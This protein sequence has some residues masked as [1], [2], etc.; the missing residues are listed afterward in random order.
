M[1]KKSFTLIRIKPC[2]RNERRISPART[3]KKTWA[4]ENI[5]PFLSLNLKA[6]LFN[7]FRLFSSIMANTLYLN[8]NRKNHRTSA[9]N[10]EEVLLQKIDAFIF[11]SLEV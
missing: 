9:G 11:D 7:L 5:V 2:L 8:N 3:R 4:I 6:L 1:I 10:F